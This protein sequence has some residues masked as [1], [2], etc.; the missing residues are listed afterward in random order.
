MK[1]PVIVTLDVS[2]TVFQIDTFRS[3]TLDDLERAISSNFVGISL[4]FATTVKIMKV[5]SATCSPQNVLFSDV[6]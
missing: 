3:M 4:D 2:S 5:L 6:L 1:L